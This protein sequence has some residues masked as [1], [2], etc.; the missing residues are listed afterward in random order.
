MSNELFRLVRVY[1][2]YTQQEFAK[3]L[4]VS[5][6]TVYGIEA[7]NRRVTETVRAKVARKF[8]AGDDFQEFVDRNKKLSK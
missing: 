8:R 1:L 3:W 4:D 7:G 2:G 6:S 5:Y